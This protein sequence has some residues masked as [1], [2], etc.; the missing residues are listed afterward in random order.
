MSLKTRII[1]AVVSISCIANIFLSLYFTGQMKKTE[2]ETLNKRI[3]DTCRMMQLVNARPLYNVDRDALTVN[4]KTFFAD[5]NMK[6]IRLEEADIDLEIEFTRNEDFEMGVDI[7][8]HFSLEFNKIKLGHMDVVYST[9]LIEKKI[10]TVRNKMIS[11]TLIIMVGLIM[12]IVLIVNRLM[13]PVSQLTKAASEI[14]AGNLELEIRQDAPGEVGEL[15]SNFSAMRDAVIEKMNDLAQSNTELANEILQKEIHEKKIMRQSAVIKAVNTFFQQAVHAESYREI[16]RLFI[17]ILLE[18]VP[19]PY[20]FIGEV[21]RDDESQIDVLAISKQART[22][23]RMARIDNDI[24]SQGQCIRGIRERVIQQNAT[25]ISNS[26]ATCSEFVKLPDRHIPIDTFMGVPMSLGTEIKGIIALAGKENGYDQEDQ[27]AAEM[28]AVALVEAL[29]LKRREQDKERLEEMMIQS[30]KMISVG[31]LAAGMAHEI[32]NPLAGILQNSQVIRNRLKERLPANIETAQQLGISLDDIERYM[33]QRDIFTMLDS[34]L[35]AGKRA[36]GIVSNMLSFSRKSDSQ[37][38]P[39]Q[40]PELLEKTLEL[41]ESDYNLKK[42]FDFKQIR[43][44]RDYE[45]DLPPVMCKASEIQQVFFNILSNGAQAMMGMKKEDR[46]PAFT[47]KV[48]R[49]NQFIVIEIKDNGP[50]MDEDTRKRIFEPFFT[51][52]SVGDGTGLGLA[53]SYFIITENH[54]G[55]IAVHSLPE[56]GSTFVI[57]LPC[58]SL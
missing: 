35:D 58:Q 50:G 48:H 26:P 44:I 1:I 40:I 53:V 28:L 45:S 4:L 31:G 14:A 54:K 19:S 33:A 46:S 55:T 27:A 32:N 51:T 20:C 12:L 16:A 6:H 11:M 39:E 10:A 15:A 38:L 52:K 3:D 7:A 24:K 9:G 36:A 57:K 22:D 17:P 8:R 56:K 2:L 37:F 47:L 23:C 21:S 41:A 49:H 5:K 13:K 30:E 29:S 34:V 25:L 18:V 42:Q 43:K